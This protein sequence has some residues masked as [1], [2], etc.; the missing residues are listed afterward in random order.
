MELSWTMRFRILAA[1]A[2]GIIL[3]GLL[4]WNLVKP[5]ANEVF[6]FLSGNISLSDVL[7]CAA[8]AFAAGFLASLVCTP[9]GSQIGIIAA[10]AGMAVWALRSAPLSMLF[11]EAPAVAERMKVYS[12]LKYEGFV[13]LALAVCGFAGA[14]AADKIFRRKTVE[15]PD[16]TK[17]FFQIPEFAQMVISII[18]TVLVANFLINIFAIDVNFTDSQLGQ[19]TAQPANL[20][21]AFAVLLSF[22]ICGFLAKMFLSAKAFWPAIASVVV[23]YY[24]TNIYIKTGTLTLLALVWPA[25]FFQRPVTAVLPI[26]MVSFACLGSLWGY[27][28]AVRYHL[29]RTYQS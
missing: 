6:A 18:A 8:L 11:Q 20:Q 12:A 26:Q 29:W 21:I 3:L 1:L 25:V 19:V 10:P 5:D 28:L 13:W 22:G 16:E 4:P 24:F 14:V 15:L 27:W 9:F 17:P 23:T 2:I 7:I